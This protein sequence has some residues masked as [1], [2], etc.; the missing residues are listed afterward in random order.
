MTLEEGEYRVKR[1]SCH[2]KKNKDI[3]NDTYIR[4]SLLSISVCV[5]QPALMML[6]K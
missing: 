5:F 1:I 4:P 2:S 6:F 3:Q